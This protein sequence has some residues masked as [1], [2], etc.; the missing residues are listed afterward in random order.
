ML[1]KGGKFMSKKKSLLVYLLIC[2]A[3]LAL[4]SCSSK[5]N[6]FSSAINTNLEKHPDCTVVFYPDFRPNGISQDMYEKY[7]K[8]STAVIV[9]E[10]KNGQILD[11]NG[12]SKNRYQ[13]LESLTK[14][15]IFTKKTA[16]EPVIDIWSKKPINNTFYI[17]S[18]Y[19]VTDS[20]KK[21]ISITDGPAISDVKLCYGHRQVS[22]IVNYTEQNSMG[23]NIAQ[24]KYNFKFVDEPSWINNTDIL[25]AFPEIDNAI[26]KSD[27]SSISVLIKTNNG[28]QA[29]L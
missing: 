18:Q 20:G 7:L 11:L 6:Q 22:Q 19:N 1:I 5:E 28:W 2:S 26:N 25:T 13:K 17:I 27:K 10:R 23:Q 12:D 3:A 21:Y 16:Q 24:V 4:Y 8:N 14:L 15:G 29:H 9:Q